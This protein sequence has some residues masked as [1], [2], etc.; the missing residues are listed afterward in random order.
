MVQN[1]NPIPIQMNNL[2]KFAIPVAASSGETQTAVGEESGRDAQPEEDP[3]LKEIMAA[4]EVLNGMIEP[5]LD[6]V[7]VDVNLLQVDF[8]KIAEKVTVAEMQINGLNLQ[9]GWKS[10]SAP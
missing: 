5:K 8:M 2:D 3:S 9:K 7:T 1:R 10:K 6:T 4:I